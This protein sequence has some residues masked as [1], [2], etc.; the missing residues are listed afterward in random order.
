M[1]TPLGLVLLGL[2]SGLLGAV[3]LVVLFALTAGTPETVAARAAV[4]AIAVL[5]F[6]ASEAL[7]WLRPWFYRA[8][9]ALVAG[10]CGVILLVGTALGR[11]SGLL[12][13]VT[14]MG[15]M[16]AFCIPILYYVH[17]E[18]RSQGMLPARPT[19]RRRPLPGRSP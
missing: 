13:A 18:A 9:L 7:I 3:L 1:R 5:A 10:L 8:S 12:I 14:L 2:L 15:V 6:V 17:D 16:L 19:P 11:G 4:A